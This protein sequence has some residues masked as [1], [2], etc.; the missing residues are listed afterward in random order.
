MGIRGPVSVS[1]RLS[2]QPIKEVISS[3]LTLYPTGLNFGSSSSREDNDLEREREE[4][5]E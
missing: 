2:A 3:D 4:S 5:L 1:L